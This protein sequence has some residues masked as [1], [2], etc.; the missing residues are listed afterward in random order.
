MPRWCARQGYIG[1]NVEYRLAPEAHYP[2]GAEDVAMALAW[3][4]AH[5]RAHGGDP[6]LIVLIGHSA[7][8]SHVASCLS[9]PA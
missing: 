3:L 5:A 6:G 9:D 7:G 8:G 2:A 4:R 1:V